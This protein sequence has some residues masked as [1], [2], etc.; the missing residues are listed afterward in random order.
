MAMKNII[1]LNNI[2]CN[3]FSDFQ[4]RGLPAQPVRHPLPPGAGQH[5]QGWQGPPQGI[6][7]F[8]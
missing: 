6:F 4:P 7:I 3:C 1:K 2:M 8:I 5:H